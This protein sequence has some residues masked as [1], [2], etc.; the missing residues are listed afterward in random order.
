MHAP[1]PSPCPLIPGKAGI[2]GHELHSVTLALGP[3]LRGDERRE[4]LHPGMRAALGLIFTV[5]ASHAVAQPV[6]DDSVAA[7][8]RGKARPLVEEDESHSDAELPVAIARSR[9]D[10]TK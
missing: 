2:Q 7:F 6:A 10:A 8:Y 3:R 9:T 1:R 5:I 4:K